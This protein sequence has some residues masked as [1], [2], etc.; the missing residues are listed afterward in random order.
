M[1]PFGDRRGGWISNHALEFVRKKARVAGECLGPGRPFR[2][3]LNLACA[4]GSAQY[5]R[6]G[7]RILA[8]LSGECLQPR[9]R[10][11]AD[12]G[13]SRAKYGMAA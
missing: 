10:W 3:A 1:R 8:R 5:F 4:V 9:W 2:A 11:C 12:Y 13:G 7:R 6:R